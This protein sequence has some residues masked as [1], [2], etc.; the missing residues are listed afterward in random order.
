MKTRKF[1]GKG[2]VTALVMSSAILFASC[3]KDD[4]DNTPMRTYNIS[5][6]ASGSQMV[7][8]VTGTGTGSIS[9]TYNPN[10]HTLTYTSNWNGLTGAP[11]AGGL[12]SGASG[13]NG[14][15]VGTGWTFP[16]GSTGTGSYNGTMT[17][18]DAQANELTSGNWYYTYSTA[19]NP[20]GEV[21]GQITATQ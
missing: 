10:N 11:T 20:T 13:T 1:L 19:T 9:G 18:T 12:Y 8:S 3:D 16:G 15:A 17:L 7:P 4:D 5:G 6:N 2:L 14:T 21:R